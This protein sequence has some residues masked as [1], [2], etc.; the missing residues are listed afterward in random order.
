L[1]TAFFEKSD[2][3][4]NLLRRRKY[5]SIRLKLITKSAHLKPLRQEF[6]TQ[7]VS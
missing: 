2:F 3:R 7:D 5:A 6:D 4:P 1:S